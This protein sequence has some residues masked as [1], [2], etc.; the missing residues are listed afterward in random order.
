MR[1]VISSVCASRGIGLE[2]RTVGERDGDSPNVDGAGS[3]GSAEKRELHAVM[4]GM[5]RDEREERDK[6]EQGRVE[7]R[8]HVLP[9]GKVSFTISLDF[10]GS[11]SFFISWM[12]LTDFLRC[13]EFITSS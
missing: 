9:S 6:G 4:E 12:K 11:L 3:F 2:R 8:T 13:K 7:K 5:R 1:K 10:W